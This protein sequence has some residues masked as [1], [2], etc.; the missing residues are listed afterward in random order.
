MYFMA[1]AKVV[2]LI[3]V[4][5]CVLHKLTERLNYFHVWSAVLKK[6]EGMLLPDQLP[7]LL[8]DVRLLLLLTG[9][10]PQPLPPWPSDP[11]ADH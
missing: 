5:S 11:T 1:L 9:I 4:C 8:S 7:T 2:S 10:P 3:L 6:V